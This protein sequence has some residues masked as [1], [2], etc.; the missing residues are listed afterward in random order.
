MYLGS[1]YMY[2]YMYMY[3]YEYMMCVYTLATVVGSCPVMLLMQCCRR[4]LD[5]G[6]MCC[7]R[8]A[9]C[10]VLCAGPCS[11]QRLPR[12]LQVFSQREYASSK[13][14]WQLSLASPAFPHF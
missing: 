7:A 14:H 2:M 8:C 6:A 4:G 3:M 13:L 11:N 9:S 5:H 12:L 10:T 1:S